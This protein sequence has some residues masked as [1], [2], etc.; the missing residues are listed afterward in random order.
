MGKEKIIIDDTEHL[1]KDKKIR[2]EIVEFFEEIKKE[3]S[4]N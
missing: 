2:K 1:N 4:T 3:A